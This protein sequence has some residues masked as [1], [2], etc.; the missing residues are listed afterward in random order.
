MEKNVRIPNYQGDK[1]PVPNHSK[2]WTTEHSEFPNPVNP[3]A[4]RST[5]NLPQAREEI[6]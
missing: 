4:S 2:T 3:K 1:D 6:R 5:R